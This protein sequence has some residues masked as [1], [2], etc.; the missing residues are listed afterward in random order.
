MEN[1]LN[2][3]PGDLVDVIFP[4]GF[5]LE[6]KETELTEDRKLKSV[7][8]SSVCTRMVAYYWDD[9]D[10]RCLDFYFYN[11]NIP[12]SNWFAKQYYLTPESRK[13]VEEFVRSNY[14]K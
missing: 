10:H 6:Y 1:L 9:D 4:E 12:N 11:D 5:T 14:K 13:K 2:I 7:V 3:C 8:R